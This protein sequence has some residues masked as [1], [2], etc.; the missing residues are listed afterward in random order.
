MWTEGQPCEDT[1]RRWPL[2]S[3]GER[4]QEKPDPT[5]TFLLDF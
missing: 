4:P 2:V 5:D 1:M 3:Q